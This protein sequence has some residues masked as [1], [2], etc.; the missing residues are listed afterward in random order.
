MS[1]VSVKLSAFEVPMSSHIVTKDCYEKAS[2]LGHPRSLQ[3]PTPL[4]QLL[5]MQ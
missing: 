1:E 3:E 5:Y 4:T 2:R